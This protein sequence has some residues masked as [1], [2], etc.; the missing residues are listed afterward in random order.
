ME[1]T[2]I[3]AQI[4]HEWFFADS[5]NLYIY[6]VERKGSGSLPELGVILYQGLDFEHSDFSQLA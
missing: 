6:L 5:E 4:R 2:G 1:L 3:L